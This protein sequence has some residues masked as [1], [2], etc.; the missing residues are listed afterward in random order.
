MKTIG[1]RIQGL[2]KDK[3]LTQEQFSSQTGFTREKIN[4][5][6]NNIREIKA[7]HIVAL[8]EFFDVSCDYILRG[9]NPK[10]K[11][12]Y[13]WHMKDTLE[14]LMRDDELIK[15]MGAY[16][17]ANETNSQ[18]LNLNELMSLSKY[19]TLKYS[20]NGFNDDTPF[21]IM[22]KIQKHL[23]D[24]REKIQDESKRGGKK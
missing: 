9:F 24:L 6:E 2:R 18:S 20:L 13:D 1:E 10:E 11:T 14:T 15:L 3:G 23:L 4:H 19:N 8:A 12:Y 16:L 17:F 7:E 5:W 21:M 22:L